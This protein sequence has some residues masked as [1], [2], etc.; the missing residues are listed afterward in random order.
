MIYK[1]AKNFNVVIAYGDTTGLTDADEAAFI[2]WEQTL[3]ANHYLVVVDD[4][5]WGRCD[6]TGY[7][8]ELIEVKMEL[9]NH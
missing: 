1:I 3:P 5:G 4:N 9:L 8:S 2:E 6:I 7:D